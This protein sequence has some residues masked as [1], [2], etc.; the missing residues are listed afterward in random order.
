MTSNNDEKPN[1]RQMLTALG[2]AA[3]AAAIVVSATGKAHAQS[4]TLSFVVDRYR[5]YYHSA[6]QYNWEA[7]I[8][9]YSVGPDQSCVLYFMKEG[10]AIPA[11]TVS[12]N[13]NSANV[14]F[15]NG[16]LAEVREFLRNERPVRIG[17]AGSNGIATLSND[18][19]EFVGDG[20]I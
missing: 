1:R 16:R 13:G 20:D 7:R 4:L 18:E 17:V 2:G 19:F 14:Y 3:A 11:N 9:L 10:E 8:Y 6:P 5:A 12:A 15:R